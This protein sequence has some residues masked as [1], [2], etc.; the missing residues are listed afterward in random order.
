MDKEVKLNVI[1]KDGEVRVLT[2][3]TFYELQDCTE[4]TFKTDCIKSFVTYVQKSVNNNLAKVFYVRG[5]ARCILTEIDYTSRDLASLVMKKSEVLIKV[6]ELNN[7]GLNPANMDEYLT[8]LRPYFGA[9][10]QTF[11]SKVRSTIVKAVTEA[12]RTVDST[13]NYTYMVTRKGMGREELGI[14][15]TVDFIIPVFELLDDV[16]QLQFEPTFSFVETGDAKEPLKMTWS[17]R[18]INVDEVIKIAQLAIM[19]KYFEP[20]NQDNCLYGELEI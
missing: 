14:P 7:R 6:L 9:G 1:T 2:G 12:E 3:K 20:L 11:Y 18:C 4:A 8:I 13:G 17:L 19:K 16:I 5:S 15:E 10:A